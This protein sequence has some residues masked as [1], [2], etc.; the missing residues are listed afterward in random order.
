MCL[1]QSLWKEKFEVAFFLLFL[2]TMNFFFF[3]CLYSSL[4]EVIP[5]DLQR[6]RTKV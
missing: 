4:V 1:L 6:G 5:L 3:C 2:V